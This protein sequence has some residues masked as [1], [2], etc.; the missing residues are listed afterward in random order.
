M[1]LVNGDVFAVI[2]NGWYFPTWVVGASRM[3][4]VD[5]TDVGAVLH[6]VARARQPQ[7]QQEHD[8]HDEDDGGSFH[9]GPRR[10]NDVD[11]S[12]ETNCFSLNCEWTVRRSNL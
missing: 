4:D 10:R 1:T 2:G 8:H 11:A 12:F 5:D 6:A 3:R 9:S 7:H